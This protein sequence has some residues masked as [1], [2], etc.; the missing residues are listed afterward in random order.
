MPIWTIREAAFLAC[1]CK[2]GMASIIST[3][4]NQDPADLIDLMERHRATG[5]LPQPLSPRNFVEWTERN[6]VSCSQTLKDRIA[7]ILG[8]TPSALE[9]DYAALKEAFQ[10]LL[11]ENEALKKSFTQQASKPLHTKERESLLKLVI[12]MAVSRYCYN[13][14]VARSDAVPTIL[15]DMEK[16]GISIDKDTIRTWLRAGADFLPGTKE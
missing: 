5:T 15:G 12:G 6:G 8:A 13:P 4:T 16:C 1:D 3:T 9:R 7:E 14:K 11:L 2:P 10:Q